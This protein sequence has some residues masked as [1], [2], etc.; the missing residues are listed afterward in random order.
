MT[1]K[2]LIL[3]AAGICLFGSSA[4]AEQSQGAM[5]LSDAHMDNVVAGEVIAILKV[6]ETG[7][8]KIIGFRNDGGPGKLLAGGGNDTN[9]TDPLN[10]VVYSDSTTL[11]II[12][13][14]TMV[15][16]PSNGKGNFFYTLTMSTK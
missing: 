4:F 1:I 9:G 10:G 16:A 2:S 13:D 7:N 8:G 11:I 3:A 12:Q 14:G 15:G 5:L 6:H